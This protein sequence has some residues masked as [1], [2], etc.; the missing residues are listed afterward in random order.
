M[1]TIYYHL[2]I[3][4]SKSMAPYWNDLIKHL[5]AHL[6]KTSQLK[7]KYAIELKFSSSAFNTE[8]YFS[9]AQNVQ[10]FKN[11]NPQGLTALYDAIMINIHLVKNALSLSIGADVQMVVFVVL[12][13]GHEN[14]SKLYA[15]NQVRQAIVKLQQQGKWE[16]IFFGAGLDIKEINKVLEIPNFKYHNFDKNELNLAFEA[17]D[18]IMEQTLK[19]IV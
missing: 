12:T 11:L 19:N 1:K 4:A 2:L 8:N 10:H 5:I 13:D 6:K 14:A 7:A 3:D 16:F 18:Q 9:N 17:L 15:A